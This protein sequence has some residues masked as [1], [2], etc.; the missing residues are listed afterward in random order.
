LLNFRPFKNEFYYGENNHL[1]FDLILVDESSMIDVFL[2]KQLFS[3]I[4]FEKTKLILLGD[5]NQLPSVQ[6]GNTLSDLI[7]T[8]NIQPSKKIQEF[9]LSFFSQ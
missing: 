9:L 8:S 7:P 4:S 3:A 2:L 5:H 1:P 6:E